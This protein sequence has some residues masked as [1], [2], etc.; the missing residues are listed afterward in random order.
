MQ[1]RFPGEPRLIACRAP[2]WRWLACVSVVWMVWAG[3]AHALVAPDAEQAARLPIKIEILGP[4]NRAHLNADRSGVRLPSDGSEARFLVRFHLPA[5]SLGESRWLLRFNRVELKR[6]QL[7]APGWEPAAQ[8]FFDPRAEEGLLPMA[9]EQILPGEWSGPVSVEVTAS[10]DLVRTLRPQVMRAAL[11]HEQ[12]KRALAIAVA[13][14]AGVLV[15]GVVAVS[16]LVGVRE[17]AFVSFLAFMCATLMLMLTAN[18]HAYTLPALAWMRP[19]GAQ[20]LNVSMLMV[21]A[22]GVM[23]AR[24][25]AGKLPNN[26]WLRWLPVAGASAL[27]ALAVA[28]LLGLR[29]GVSMMQTLVTVG[30]VT[31]GLLSL[32]AFVNAMLRKAWLGWLLLCAL[33]LLGASCTLFELSVRGIGHAFW[34]QFGYQ[35][36][37]VLVALVMVLA[38][39]GRIADFRLKH[40]RERTARRASEQ[41][42]QQQQAYAALAVQL[43]QRLTDVAPNDLEWVAIQ[44]AMERLLPLLRLSSATILLYRAGYDQ[45]RITEPVTH[46]SRIGA[47]IDA[48]AETLHAVLK[49]QVAMNDLRLVLPKAAGVPRRNGVPAYAAV[50]LIASAGTGGVALLERAGAQ[51]FDEEELALATRFGLLVLERTAE[52]RANHKLRRSAELDA[53]TGLLNRNAIDSALRAAF[54]A[55]HQKQEPLAV[56]FADVDR[57]KAINDTYGHACGDLCLQRIAATLRHALRP[58]DLLGRY[59]GE[60]FVIVLIGPAADRAREVGERMRMLVEQAEVPWQGEM[61]KLTISIGVATRLPHEPTPTAALERADR[62]LYAAKHEGRNRVNLAT[63]PDY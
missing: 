60:E 34:G 25:Y 23:V 59:G 15:L 63:P 43:Q 48:N 7:R 61:L 18:G 8:S 19:L 20:G 28:T 21:C 51:P 39:V 54:A 9:F 29:L 53:L 41:R 13:L 45:V 17:L 58:G 16:L 26:P 33:V 50:P 57:F 44:M 5:R 10:T 14:Y 1:P 2:A 37:L 46:T 42:L 47:L 62:A 36:G 52:A 11:A 24:D 55:S 22:F 4:A 12:D 35:V 31:A 27:L 6:L 32:L 3:M 49:R 56:L 38:L 30:W 40:E